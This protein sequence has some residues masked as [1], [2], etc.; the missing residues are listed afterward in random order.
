M[1]PTKISLINLN[2]FLY[3]SKAVLLGIAIFLFT[4]NFEPRKI[5]PVNEKEKAQ[6]QKIDLVIMLSEI[7][8]NPDGV[9]IID[10][11]LT[12]YYKQSRI[13][14]A[15]SIDMSKDGESA[16]TVAQTYNSTPE[17]KHV[18]V[19]GNRSDPTAELFVMQLFEAGLDK[20]QFFYP[21][22]EQWRVCGLPITND[23]GQ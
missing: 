19:Y 14:R 11:R 12:D 5:S 23:D 20:V 1:Q 22:F 16:E 15:I 9:V 13:P 10:A 2:L 4:W 18:I 3:I 6:F 21:G 8:K 7:T 17:V